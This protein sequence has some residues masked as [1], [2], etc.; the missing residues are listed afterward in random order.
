MSSWAQAECTIPLKKTI[1]LLSKH[2]VIINIKNCRKKVFYS[3][4]IENFISFNLH[5]LRS[6]NYKL[7]RF[8]SPVSVRPVF[9]PAIFFYADPPRM[10]GNFMRSKSFVVADRPLFPLG[11]FLIGFPLR[12]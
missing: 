2:G 3:Q 10:L 4:M 6:Y 8:L 9:E 1:P 5:N 7:Y 12:T 11:V